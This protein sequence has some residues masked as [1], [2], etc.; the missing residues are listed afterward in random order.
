[1]ATS[2]SGGSTGNGRESHSKRLGCK[3]YGGEVVIAGNILIRQRGTKFHAGNGV[4]H[5]TDDT[6]YALR[7]G[8]VNYKLKGYK[9]RMFVSVL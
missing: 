4:G 7:D 5:G 9:K 2:K 3:K 1:M 8:V 6:L